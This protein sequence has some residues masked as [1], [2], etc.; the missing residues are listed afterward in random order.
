MI[1]EKFKAVGFKDVQ[2]SGN[3][4]ERKATGVW[5][6]KTEEV[7]TIPQQVTNIVKV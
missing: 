6:G 4:V 3:G 2:V 7:K 1:A 5:A